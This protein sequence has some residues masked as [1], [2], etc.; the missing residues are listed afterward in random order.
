MIDFLY[1]MLKYHFLKYIFFI[2]DLT[3]EEK[4]R[5][6]LLKS[7]QVS[8]F[9]C[10]KKI[11]RGTSKEIPRFSVFNPLAQQNHVSFRHSHGIKS[12]SRVVFFK[13]SKINVDDVINIWLSFINCCMMI[14]IDQSYIIT[15]FLNYIERVDCQ[16]I[17]SIDQIPGDLWS[18]PSWSS[19]VPA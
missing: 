3:F 8:F 4:L 11:K 10:R 6:G 18:S 12:F 14:K 19:S 5:T 17:M 9:V 16:Q 2:F 1:V 13:R 7:S 15:V